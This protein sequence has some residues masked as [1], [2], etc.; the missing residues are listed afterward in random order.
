MC[1]YACMCVCLSVRMCMCVE[2]FRNPLTGLESSTPHGGAVFLNLTYFNDE[3]I[4]L[5]CIALF[6]LCRVVTQWKRNNTKQK[7]R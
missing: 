1:T 3:L 4:Y 5:V 6:C 7:I 2:H